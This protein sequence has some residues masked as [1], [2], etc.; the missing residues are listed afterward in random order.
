MRDEERHGREA[1]DR[2]EKSVRT[3]FF[4]LP[5]DQQEQDAGGSGEAAEK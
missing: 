3:D 5:C 4:C 1:E 2:H